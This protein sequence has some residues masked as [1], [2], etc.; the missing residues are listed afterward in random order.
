[1]Q[2]TVNKKYALGMPGEFYDDSPRRVSTFTLKRNITTAGVKA[3]GTLTATAN[4]SSS[5]TVTVGNTTYTFGSSAGNIAVGADLATSLAS[6]AAAINADGLVTAAATATT[7]VL[8]A[9]EAGTAA[10]SIATTET[11][12][13][14][15]FGGATLSG[16]VDEVVKNPK[17]ARAFT[18]LENEGEAGVGGTGLFAGLL[19]EPKG[20]A[21]YN[22]FA[23]T[24]EVSDGVAGQL[25]TFGHVLVDVAD[26]V[27]IG[28]TAFFSQADGSIIGGT[29]GSSISNYT[30]IKNSKFVFFAAAAGETAVLELN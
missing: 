21:R 7:I 11:C 30:E 25:C 2:K 1:M 26:A 22:N 15:S 10:N 6:L 24:M 3:T 18:Y 28:Q 5:E 12:T 4:F 27:S 9:K 29:A 13:N 20:F 17:V 23:P 16:G 14:A 8:T 19:V